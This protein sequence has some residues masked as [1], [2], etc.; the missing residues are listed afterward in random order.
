MVARLALAPCTARLTRAIGRFSLLQLSSWRWLWSCSPFGCPRLATEQAAHRAPVALGHDAGAAEPPLLAGGLLGEQVVQLGVAAQ[1]LAVLG[2]GEAAGGTAVALHLGHGRGLPALAVCSRTFRW[3]GSS[4][5]PTA[6]PRAPAPWEPLS[7][8]PR[9][10]SCAARGL[11]VRVCAPGPRGRRPWAAPRSCVARRPRS[12][13][14]RPAEPDYRPGRC[15][16]CRWPA[17]RAGAGRARC[18]PSPVRGT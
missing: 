17:V 18:A 14:G 2:H 4:L 16:R 11:P 7:S 5:P 13:C 6:P 9:A 15:Q 8:A 3:G 12:C 10:A 1:Q